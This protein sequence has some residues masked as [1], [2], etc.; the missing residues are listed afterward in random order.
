MPPPSDHDALQLAVLEKP[1]FVRQVK[2][3]SPEVLDE[4]RPASS[5]AFYSV[6]R[7][8]EEISIVGE[9]A[10]GAPAAEAKWRCVRVKGPMDFGERA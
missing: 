5:G 10:E 3:I 9:A 4:L 2:K 1:F 8:A 7:T 6:T